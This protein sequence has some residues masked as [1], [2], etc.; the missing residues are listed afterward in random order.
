MQ[1]LKTHYGRAIPI[2]Y[3]DT[4]NMPNPA[5]AGLK[6]ITTDGDTNI[7]IDTS[8]KFTTNMI[9]NTVITSYNDIAT[10]TGFIDEHTLIIS[11]DITQNDGV[12]YTLYVP[13]PNEGF[14]I[15]I[16][17]GQASTSTIKLLTVGGDIVTF[18]AVGDAAASIILPVQALRVF[19]SSTNITGL[20]ALW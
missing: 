15:Y 8:V 13:T 20:I 7:L 10:V 19:E 5:N 3:S 16:P 9:G 14:S 18:T 11:S 1:Y 2:I 4:I 17:G 6:S 12:G